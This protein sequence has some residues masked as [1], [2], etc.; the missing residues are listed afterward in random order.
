M[1]PSIIQ[2]NFLTLDELTYISNII[3]TNGNLYEDIINNNLHSYY[4]TW[5]FYSKDFKEIYNIFEEKL[6]SLTDI[7]LIIDHSHILH[8]KIPYGLHTDFYQRKK[9]P[10]SLVPAYTLIIPL[11]NYDTNTLVFNQTAEEKD[12][13]TYIQNNTKIDKDNSITDNFYNQYLT[14]CDRD[15]VDYLS[16]KEVFKWHRGAI[17]ACDRRYFHC[18]DNYYKNNLIEKKAIIMWTSVLQN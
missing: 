13:K 17:H 9:L 1:L 5:S 7:K 8:S 2:E 12:I 4:Y 10:S 16:L 6:K 14:H 18:S 11:D 3:S 15:E